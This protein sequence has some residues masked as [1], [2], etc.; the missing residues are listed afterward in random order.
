MTSVI[1]AGVYAGL[2]RRG[3]RALHALLGADDPVDLGED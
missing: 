1:A 2:A 3:P